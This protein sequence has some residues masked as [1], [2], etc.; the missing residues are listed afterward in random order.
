MV[1][2]PDE[3]NRAPNITML[4]INIHTVYVY[5]IRPANVFFVFITAPGRGLLPRQSFP[6]L[7]PLLLRDPDDVRLPL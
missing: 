6:Q 4:A 7:S 1:V 3:A 2:C 5:I